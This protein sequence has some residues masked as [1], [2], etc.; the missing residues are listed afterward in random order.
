ML[1]DPGVRLD[2]AVDPRAVSECGAENS[3][4]EKNTVP[5]SDALFMLSGTLDGVEK[6]I[7]IGSPADQRGAGWCS[8][9][10]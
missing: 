9:I 7:P 3:M 10:N 8:T 4:I 6:E 5:Y 2:L 1:P